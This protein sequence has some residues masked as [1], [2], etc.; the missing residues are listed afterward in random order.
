MGEFE[1][2]GR[3]VEVQLR[4]VGVSSAIYGERLWLYCQLRSFLVPKLVAN[5]MGHHLSTLSAL[6]L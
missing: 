6:E 5:Y 1:G 4:L 2:C 3:V